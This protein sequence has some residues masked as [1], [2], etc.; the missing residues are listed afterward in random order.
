MLELEFNVGKPRFG[1]SGMT[2]NILL[3]EEII[4]GLRNQLAQTMHLGAQWNGERCHTTRWRSGWRPEPLG[5]IVEGI[6]LGVGVELICNGAFD[7]KKRKI[8]SG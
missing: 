5:R 3:V 1:A 7:G 6:T 8:K 2:L 4:F